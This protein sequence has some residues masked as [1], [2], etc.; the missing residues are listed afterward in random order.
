MPTPL[1]IMFHDI[2]RSEALEQHIRDRLETLEH[3]YPKL[4]RCNV[5]IEK[6]HRHKHQG[7]AF[8]V[9]IDLHVPGDEI[10]VTRDAHEDA[11]VALRDAF[12]VAKRLIMQRAQKVRGDVKR[13]SQPGHE[14]DRTREQQ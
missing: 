7:N 14:E 8:R 10:V 6:P 9:R 12:D 1:N 5:T 11:Y 3:L 13:H 4:T 2:A